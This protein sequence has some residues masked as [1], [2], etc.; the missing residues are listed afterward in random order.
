MTRVEYTCETSRK[1]SDKFLEL[2]GAVADGGSASS[3]QAMR[4]LQ[5]ILEEDR[6]ARQPSRRSPAAAQTGYDFAVPP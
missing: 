3:A 5:D 4:R 2:V 6:G 1:L